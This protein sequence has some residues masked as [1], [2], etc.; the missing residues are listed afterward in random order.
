MAFFVSVKKIPGKKPPLLSLTGWWLPV[1]AGMISWAC[2]L[3]GTRRRR[4]ITGR[5]M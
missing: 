3:A 5:I 4:T 1:A 2:R